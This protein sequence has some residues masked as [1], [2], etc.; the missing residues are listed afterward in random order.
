MY[1]VLFEI[2]NIEVTALA[3]FF[4]IGMLVFGISLWSQIRDKSTFVFDVFFLNLFISPIVAKIAY[5][6]V[7]NVEKGWSL[8]P[9]SE[10][11]E[12]I[13]LFEKLPWNVFAFWDG[14]LNF[15]FVP[16]GLF[17]S[18]VVVG[19]FHRDKFVKFDH[20]GIWQSFLMGFLF[21]LLGMFFDGTYLS[22][23]SDFPFMLR[24][25]GQS[26]DLLPIQI[27]EI[28]AVVVWLAFFSISFEL[29]SRFLSALQVYGFPVYWVFVQIFVWFNLKQYSQDFYFLDNAQLIWLS[30]LVVVIFVYLY[31]FSSFGLSDKKSK[32]S[33]KLNGMRRKESDYHYSFS[34]YKSRVKTKKSTREL[35]KQTRNRIKRS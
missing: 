30:F 23:V 17:L 28:L 1:P 10:S 2:Q 8:L 33:K 3:L 15:Q 4:V 18:L 21:L 24:Y 29:R 19:F 22:D 5:L 27:F 32:D 13:L 34:N 25:K 20:K 12:K 35:L 11:G 9:L 6:L 26:Q 7:T 16:I 14:D 31:S